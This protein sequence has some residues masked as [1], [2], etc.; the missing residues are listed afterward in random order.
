MS[1]KYK[2]EQLADGELETE[3]PAQNRKDEIGDMSGAVQ[4]FKEN[5]IRTKELEADQERQKQVAEEEK[6][7]TMNA[8]GDD[9]DASVGGIVETVSSAS[10]EVEQH[11][12]VHGQHL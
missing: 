12:P 7:K 3:V 2:Y 9:F 8:L 6:H 4:V 11:G 5:M 10:A 1:F